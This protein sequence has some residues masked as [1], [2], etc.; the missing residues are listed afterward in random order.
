MELK[1]GAAHYDYYEPMS[2]TPMAC[3]TMREHIVPDS[4]ADIARI[5]ESTGQVYVTGRELSGDGR[6]CA[7]GTVDVS[8]LYIPEKGNGPCVLR[9]QMP[10]QCCSDGQVNGGAE[11]LDIRAELQGVDT[12]LLNPRKVLTRVNLVLHPTLCRRVTR[13]LCTDALE[14]GEI[15]LLSCQRQTR[16]VASVREKEFTYLEE[17]PLSQG[18]EGAEEI[19]SC[20]AEVRGTDCKLI[21]TKLVLKGVVAVTVLYR[22]SGG[23]LELTR[24]ELPF[25]Q[26]LDGSELREQWDCESMYHI[27]N[28]DCHIGCENGADDHHVLTLSLLL[29]A[30]VTV[31]RN[32]EIH[33]IADLYSTKA[34]V[35]CQTEEFQ[36]REDHQRYTK[37]VN[38]R[39]TLET[40]VAVKAVLDTE[41]G[42]GHVRIDSAAQMMEIPVWARCLYWDENDSLQSVRREFVAKCPTEEAE[43]VQ[44]ESCAQYRGDVMASILPDGIELRFPIECAVEASRL[45]TYVCVNGGEIEEEQAHGTAPSLVLRRIA[46]NE[47]LWSVAKAYRTTCKAIL[48]INEL[49]DEHHIPSDKLLLIPQRR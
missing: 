29:R 3:E 30:R 13:S 28:A 48:E 26:I 40:G 6:L 39:E 43:D 38:M 25:S 12:R 46:P 16:F 35:R 31:W 9:F 36:L 42:C 27:L 14:G 44:I 34:D 4:C 20:R 7:S 17:I 8:V 41:I 11:F 47:R 19:L 37:R 21:G 32:E 24:N 33:F 5:V 1:L 22:E 15:E 23:A 45:H 18:R 2:L 10:F 49:E